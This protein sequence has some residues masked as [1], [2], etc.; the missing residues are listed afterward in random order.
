MTSSRK[1]SK[2][3]IVRAYREFES[4]RPRR[5]PWLIALGCAAL[6]SLAGAGSGRA[7]GVSAKEY[8]VK[9]AFIYKT[10][11]Y[12]EW[13]Q[14]VFEKPDSPI[15]IGVLG[16]DPFGSILDKTVAEKTMDGRPFSI[17]RFKS[18]EE[19]RNCHILFVSSS[20]IGNLR[21]IREALKDGPILTFGDTPGFVDRGGMINFVA[22]EDE[23]KIQF[24]ANNKAAGKANLKI[25][26]KLLK[27][28]VRVI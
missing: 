7:A 11:R 18:P 27:L 4:A 15:V 10:A 26:S 25:S 3:S 6:V 22:G 19:A 16:K 28:A 23:S 12:V 2:I 20:E 24:E 13:P 1:H 21:Q 9:A 17:S 8:E 5:R 14:Y